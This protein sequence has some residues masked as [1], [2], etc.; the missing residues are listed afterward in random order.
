MYQTLAALVGICAVLAA[1]IVIFRYQLL[2]IFL[3]KVEAAEAIAV[4]SRYLTVVCVAYMVAAVMRTYL[5]VLRGA[6][7]VNTSAVAGILELT[8][9]II[10][11]YILV[12][13]FGATGI[14]V[15]TPLAWAMGA[16]VPVIRYYSGKWKNK[17][18]V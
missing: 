7:D 4:G 18:L 11:A 2:G 10:F 6:G 14:W 15:A 9:R 13:P 16:T 3:D 8:G 17:K 1:A 5:N 12:H